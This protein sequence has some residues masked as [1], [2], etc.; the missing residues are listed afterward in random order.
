MNLNF[1]HRLLLCTFLPSALII[2]LAA[3][4]FAIEQ[5]RSLELQFQQQLGQHSQS[6]LQLVNL[7]LGSDALLETLQQIN[8]SR[9]SKGVA[10]YDANRR[11]MQLELGGNQIKAYQGQSPALQLDNQQLPNKPGSEHI[12]IESNL[13]LVTHFLS[14]SSHESEGSDQISPQ[15]LQLTYDR[16]QLNYDQLT[17]RFRIFVIALM[18]LAGLYWL[19]SWLMTIFSKPIE[20]IFYAQRFYSEHQL[21]YL[22]DSQSSI[23]EFVSLQNMINDLNLK[24]RSQQMEFEERLQEHTLD[25]RKQ[26]EN[27]EGHNIRL[28][29][30][31]KE[32]RDAESIKSQF[33][34]QMSHDMRTPLNA[35]LGFSGILS[36]ILSKEPHKDK[37][38]EYLNRIIG[39]SRSLVFLVNNILEYSR[40]KADRL[41][42]NLKP[43]SLA[44]CIEDVLAQLSGHANSKKIKLSYCLTPELDCEFHLDYN[45]LKQVL[46]NLVNNAI[47]FSDNGTVRIEVTGQPVSSVTG[48]QSNQ[49]LY[50]LNF[51]A[52]DQGIGIEQQ[53]INRLFQP[54][55]QQDQ[56]NN[57]EQGS[58][59]G[60]SICRKL[61]DLMK[62]E[63]K[64]SSLVGK[65][66]N[67]S[68]N[69]KAEIAKGTTNKQDQQVL[70]EQKNRTIYLRTSDE[71]Q[72]YD[73]SNLIL[74]LGMEV[75]P[76]AD[77]GLAQL[78]TDSQLL[79]CLNNQELTNPAIT[80]LVHDHVQC[81]LALVLPWP[82]EKVTRACQTLSIDHIVAPILSYQLK[83][84]LLGQPGMQVIT[85]N[86][87]VL[88][89]DDNSN[90]RRMLEVMINHLP[91]NIDFASSGEEVL[92]L[93]HNQEFDLIFMDIQMPGLNGI[94]TMKF[95]RSQIQYRNLPIIAVTAQT[96]NNAEY[97]L[98]QEGFNDYLAKP[99]SQFQV[100]QQLQR[101][102]TKD[103]STAH[104]LISEEPAKYEP[105]PE[106]F[107][108]LDTARRYGYRLAICIEMMQGLF[109]TLEKIKQ[110]LFQQAGEELS[111]SLHWLKG[112]CKMLGVPRLNQILDTCDLAAKQNASELPELMKLLKH[113]IDD[114]LALQSSNWQQRLQT[115]ID[116]QPDA[117]IEHNGSG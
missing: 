86:K 99:F 65:G 1:H 16:Q 66:S 35:I 6:S 70:T 50:D 59:L 8:N 46:V 87:R 62:G 30:H 94:E 18:L 42:L 116:E 69:I 64:V 24:L 3:L 58:G 53:K 39:A 81:H 45:K 89:V 47:K 109:S 98:K 117:Q 5:H 72:M 56:G 22:I 41:Q 17:S 103:S 11:I 73:L 75:T 36:T 67:F 100:E 12:S 71:Q 19:L 115:A 110:T 102:L 76:I 80:Q 20:Q 9:H 88:I 77:N 51:S 52:Q 112:S 95:I 97:Q 27:F 49:L 26:I 93:M 108:P 57:V 105:E 55:S 85:N 25:L 61:V 68:F 43:I 78:P 107:D 14:N 15:W 38:N 82:V 7:A 21:E 29:T 111:S 32:A 60:L 90:N 63:F 84:L 106:V 31:L 28:Q 92:G 101:W 13:T 44:S 104:R 96:D 33:L 34:A 91:L 74:R 48:K 23:P 10:L 83:E 79:Y 54:Y 40:L 37:E 2:V 4:F 113:E 114:V